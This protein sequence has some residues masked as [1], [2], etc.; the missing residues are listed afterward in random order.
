MNLRRCELI[1]L[2]WLLAGFRFHFKVSVLTLNHV[3]WSK[4]PHSLETLY[5]SA[6]TKC[7]PLTHT[8]NMLYFTFEW[9]IRSTARIACHK[10]WRW[11]LAW[12]AFKVD[13]ANSWRIGLSMTIGHDDC[14]LMFSSSAR[15]MHFLPACGFARRNEFTAVGNR[16]LDKMDHWSDLARMLHFVWGPL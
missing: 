2:C 13:W 12:M 1:H 9:E 8:K 3:S 5:I 10:M 4:H 16:M 7:V 6:L 11:P 14:T 15:S